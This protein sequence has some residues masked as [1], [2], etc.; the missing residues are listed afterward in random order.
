M[1]NPEDKCDYV[2]YLQNLEKTVSQYLGSEIDI[3]SRGPP[4]NMRGIPKGNQNQKPAEPSGDKQFKKL[5]LIITS[6]NNQV[7][8]M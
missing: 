4:A 2:A 6:V 5:R 8:E 3:Y 7:L 1:V